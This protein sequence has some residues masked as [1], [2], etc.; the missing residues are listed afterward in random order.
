MCKK[1]FWFT[2]AIIVI[3]FQPHN[4]ASVKEEHDIKNHPLMHQRNL[5]LLHKIT[6]KVSDK[7][8]A[9]AFDKKKILIGLGQSPAYLLEMLKVMNKPNREYRHVAF[10]GFC[11]GTNGCVDPFLYEKFKKMGSYYRSYLDKIGLS[12]EALEAEDTEYIVIEVCHDG[13]GLSSFLEFFTHYP[14]TPKVIYLQNDSF[15]KPLFRISSERIPLTS[16]GEE[17]KLLIALANADEFRDRLVPHF[18]VSRWETVDPFVVNPQEGQ[19]ASIILNQLQQF[20]SQ[21]AT[22]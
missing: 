5:E 8:D 19:N 18:N 1:F 7:I 6:Q 13:K 21:L 12:Q 14:K 15:K 9:I 11:Y 3:A 17:E 20:S 4:E 22:K 16:Y 2:L 10:S